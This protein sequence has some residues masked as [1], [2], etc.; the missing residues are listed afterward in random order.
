MY[1]FSRI[2][3]IFG[4]FVGATALGACSKDTPPSQE[5]VEKSAPTPVTPEVKPETILVPAE[6]M[7]EITPELA[8]KKA[9]R[10]CK[11]C[12]TIDQGGRNRVGPNLYGVFGRQAGTAPGFAYSKAMVSSGLVW[13]EETMDAYIASPKTFIP[14]NT[15]AFIGL[16]KQTDRD[17]LIAYL[18][19][20]T[21]AE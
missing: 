3:I 14:K 19:A 5:K 12:H 15:M 17:N 11:A 8:G 2:L 9:F 21:D 6:K 7:V 20:N 1:T 16:K 10:R 4:F 13:N 18:K